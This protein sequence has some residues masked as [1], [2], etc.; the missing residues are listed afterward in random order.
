MRVSLC[1]L[2]A[3]LLVGIN[4]VTADNPTDCRYEQIKG[5]W[6]FY[7]TARDQTTDNVN[8]DELGE[9]AKEIKISLSYPNI[10][11]D[12]DGNKGTW[13][14][15]YNQGFEVIING[16]EFFAFSMFEQVK[17]NVPC[18]SDDPTGC[19]EMEKVTVTS[20]CDKTFNGWSHSDTGKDWA[21]Y[22][23]E[24]VTALAP[25]VHSTVRKLHTGKYKISMDYLKAINNSQS[26]WYTRVYDKWET[27]THEELL[28][29][30]G[31]YKSHLPN[32]PKPAP[33]SEE[34]LK[35]VADLPD[36]IDYRDIDGVNYMPPVRDQGMCGS[37]YIFCSTGAIAARLRKATNNKNQDILSPQDVLECS[38]YSQGCAGGFAYLIAGKYAKDFGFVEETCRPYHGRDGSCHKTD[39]PDCKRHYTKTYQ[40]VGGYYG[41]TN[42]AEI[43]LSLV[44]DGPVA[45]GFMV[46]A[47]FM[48]YGGG[49]YR[50]TGLNDGFDPFVATNHCVV[51]MGYGSD[52]KSGEKYWI[53]QNSWGSSWGDHG[54]F[55]LARGHDE[56]GV[57]SCASEFIPIP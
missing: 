6:I 25:S 5:D 32:R 27:M 28:N 40:Y 29:I 14:L 57:E 39:Y 16:R 21:C 9:I 19:K 35:K 24:K 20:I 26:S 55:K 2:S 42:E 8:C 49:I 48:H 1:L 33:V 54:Y 37:C 41:A 17:E 46:F 7:E 56:A 13:T 43:M 45:V 30:K 51:L 36:S 10:A 50:H 34:T 22:K 3:L 31:G 23:G 47:D 15:I 12:G 38:E 44:N 11:E 18:S 53:L 52:A 4:H